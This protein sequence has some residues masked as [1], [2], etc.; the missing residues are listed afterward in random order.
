MSALEATL[1][2][3][4]EDQWDLRCEG[5]GWSVGL[6][7]CHVG[8][9]L[10]RQARWIERV[11]AGGVAHDFSWERTHA[12][13]ALVKR[14]VLRPDPDEVLRSLRDGLERWQRLLEALTEAD[15]SRIAFRMGPNE[16]SVDWVAGTLAVR[17][18]DEH[19]RSIRAVLGDAAA[20]ASPRE[21]RNAEKR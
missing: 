3:L 15:L 18:I 14:R 2:P 7:G 12:L 13:N 8:L 17:H 20:E 9:G 19:T 1:T 21:Q 5:E 11:L 16:R 6:V 10:R 4:T